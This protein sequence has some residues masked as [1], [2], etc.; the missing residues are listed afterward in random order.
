MFLVF[1]G[2]LQI[3]VCFSV[4]ILMF[5]VVL[6]FSSENVPTIILTTV[7]FNSLEDLKALYVVKRADNAINLNHCHIDTTVHAF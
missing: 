5:Y 7:E 4:I 2:R 1:G 3:P 6:L